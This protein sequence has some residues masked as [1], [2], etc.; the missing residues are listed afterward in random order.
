MAAIQRELETIQA[1]KRAHK[2]QAAQR[3][4]EYAEH[5]DRR[6][7]GRKGRHAKR[8]DS[9]LQ[10]RSQKGQKDQPP[11]LAGNAGG[12]LAPHS[13]FAGM[14]N[15]MSGSHSHSATAAAAAVPQASN[16]N[17]R[18]RELGA[19]QPNASGQGG[20][21]KGKDGGHLGPSR[22]ATRPSGAQ[23]GRQ[24]RGEGTGGQRHGAIACAPCL[25]VGALCSLA[26][27]LPPRPLCGWIGS[28][29]VGSF[30]RRWLDIGE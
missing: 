1:A 20:A 25:H 7:G 12:A 9:K 21:G 27:P 10:R 14:Q 13:L 30:P 26:L 8:K 18:G 2:Q 3:A 22:V 19:N 24:V 4:Q 23:G 5:N 28:R 16:A 15:A 6:H 17:A 11:P 29:E